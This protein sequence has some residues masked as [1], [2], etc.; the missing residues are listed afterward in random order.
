MAERHH[1]PFHLSTKITR[2]TS[3]PRGRWWAH[4]C[5]LKM[6]LALKARAGHLR[7]CVHVHPPLCTCACVWA[8]AHVTEPD[9]G[10]RTKCLDLMNLHN[11]TSPTH[12]TAPPPKTHTSARP[13]HVPAPRR[14]L[15]SSTRQTRCS[16]TSGRATPHRRSSVAPGP[17]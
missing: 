2:T 11:V 16:R 10:Q 12:R 6:C 1:F 3:E 5:D 14:H 9:H 7:M 8:C 17:P 13:T 4:G 15:P